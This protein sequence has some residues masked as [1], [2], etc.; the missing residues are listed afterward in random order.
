M[1]IIKEIKDFTKYC[2]EFYNLKG[3][4]YPIATKE[5]IDWAI[6]KFLLQPNIVPIDFDSHDREQVRQLIGK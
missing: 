1:N 3:G 5:E 4:V 2:N 6:R